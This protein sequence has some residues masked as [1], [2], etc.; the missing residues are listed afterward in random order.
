MKTNRNKAFKLHFCSVLK[1]KKGLKHFY[2][3]ICKKNI[4][5][6]ETRILSVGWLTECNG[7][8]VNRDTH[9]VR[10]FCFRNVK[11]KKKLQIYKLRYCHSRKKSREWII[12][13]FALDKVFLENLSNL[14]LGYSFLCKIYS[15]EIVPLVHPQH[16][17]TLKG[18]KICEVISFE[19][20]NI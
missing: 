17:I 4:L 14:I 15:G 12:Q 3:K 18:V 13:P 2:F 8:R 10:I 19:E 9:R 6:S 7:T 5:N 20:E 11:H 1:L 16:T